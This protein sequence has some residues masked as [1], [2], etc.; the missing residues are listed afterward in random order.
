[1]ISTFHIACPVWYKQPHGKPLHA[2]RKSPGRPFVDD[3]RCA[4]CYAPPGRPYIRRPLGGAGN[5]APQGPPTRPGVWP[6]WVSPGVSF[7]GSPWSPK[8]LVPRGHSRVKPQ[9]PRRGL[10]LG[11]APGGPWGPWPQPPPTGRRPRAPV[12][13]QGARA[14]LG[15]PGVPKPPWAL[16]SVVAACP[17]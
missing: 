1:M 14:S 13:R 2:S 7:V 3:P 11:A 6:P 17:S 16:L 5:T 15:A 10:L 9:G 12:E 4:L 8:P